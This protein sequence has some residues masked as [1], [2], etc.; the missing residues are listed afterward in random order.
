VQREMLALLG[1]IGPVPAGFSPKD[2]LPSPEP[3]LRRE[4]LRLMLRDPNERDV[5]VMTALDD[6]DDRVVFVGL[7]AAQEKCPHGA[8]PLIKARV[9]AG[10]LDSQL[11]TMG[12]KI[13]AQQRSPE[14]LA[15]LLD[16]VLGEARW[17]RRPKLK[18]STPEMLAA[19]G[20]LASSWRS[21]PHAAGAIALAEQSKDEAVRAKVRT[22]ATA[23]GE[24]S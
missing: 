24:K 21:D 6:N 15:W 13:V 12:I 8:M 20:I 3:L 2:F 9:D 5:A 18:P 19:L 10:E 14:T 23:H 4:A 1:K 7:T 16:F 17:P 22:R 11:R